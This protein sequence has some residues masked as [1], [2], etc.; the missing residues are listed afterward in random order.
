VAVSVVILVA[1]ASAAVNIRDPMN[2]FGD[3]EVVDG[4]VSAKNQNQQ[5]ANLTLS[6]PINMQGN[7]IYN[8]GNLNAG[9]QA[10]LISS[11]NFYKASNTSENDRPTGESTL[12]EA[13]ASVSCPS[14][15]VLVGSRV[16]KG[17]ASTGPPEFNPASCDATF[18]WYGEYSKVSLNKIGPNMQTGGGVT[19]TDFGD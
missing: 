11:L 15:E 6:S 19:A 1:S 14:D 5:P 2:I 3:V 17:I 8:I 9:N 18:D 13:S 7:N 12:P 10:G 16:R 4:E